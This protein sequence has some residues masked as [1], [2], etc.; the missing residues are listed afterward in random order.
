MF[1]LLLLEH[2][3]GLYKAAYCSFTWPV[4][5]HAGLKLISTAVDQ[6]YDNQPLLQTVS[7]TVMMGDIRYLG[8]NQFQYWQS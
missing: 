2:T 7:L 3:V 1:H 4:A 8:K 6:L 5:V